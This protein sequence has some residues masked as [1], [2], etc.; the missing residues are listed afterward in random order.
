MTTI[1]IPAVIRPA[2]KAE[3]FGARDTPIMNS[4]YFIKKHLTNELQGVF[5]VAEET[6]LNEFIYQYIYQELQVIVTEGEGFCFLMNLRLADQFDVLQGE[7]LRINYSYYVLGT[8]N[9]LEGPF[10]I[11]Y[12]TDPYEIAALINNKSMYVVAKNQSFT[13]YQIKKTA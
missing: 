2:L 1:Q 7:Y 6:D 8:D 3:L 5:A 12:E 4:I 13:P 11:K 10:Q 9:S